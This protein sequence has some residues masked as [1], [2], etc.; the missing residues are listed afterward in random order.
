MANKSTIFAQLFSNRSSTTLVKLSDQ[1]SGTLFY[2][3]NSGLTPQSRGA[4]TN[5]SN[6]SAYTP[7]RAALAAAREKFNILVTLQFGTLLL[8]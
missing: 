6:F 2:Q 8:T 1:N 5:Q 7:H 3:F 4:T